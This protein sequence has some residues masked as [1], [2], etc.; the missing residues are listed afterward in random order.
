MAGGE[1]ERQVETLTAETKVPTQ[2]PIPD[3]APGFHRYINSKI[4]ATNLVHEYSATTSA[5]N[6][7]SSKR[8]HSSIVNIFPGWIF[9]PELL[10]RSKAEAF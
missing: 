3:S 5:D 9:G 7:N 6:K 2:P 1:A 10:A 8:R 4:A